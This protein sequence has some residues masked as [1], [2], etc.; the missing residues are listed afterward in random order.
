MADATDTT[1]PT[2]T[3]YVSKKL[4]DGNFG[5]DEVGIFVPIEADP[6]ADPTSDDVQLAIRNAV[7]AAKAQVAVALGISTEVDE[8]GTLVYSGLPQAAAAPAKDRGQ[9]VA[10]AFG[11]NIEGVPADPPA[12]NPE[13]G[14][15]GEKANQEWAKQRF[16]V[17]PNEFWDNRASN[18]EKAQEN[19]KAAKWPNIKHKK[20][21]RNSGW[22]RDLVGWA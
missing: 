15:A 2:Y 17:A 21:N 5:S 10:D 19:P 18:A 13:R 12:T 22:D 7:N 14:S 11:A 6:S 9:A 3:I 1:T 4:S 16:A 20:F 8:E